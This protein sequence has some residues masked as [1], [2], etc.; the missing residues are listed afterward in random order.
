M[1][2]LGIM[3]LSAAERAKK[4]RDKHREEVRRRDNLRKKYQRTILKTL[5]ERNEERLRKQREQKSLYRKKKREEEQQT[6]RHIPPSTTSALPI[7]PP[8]SFTQNS[9]KAR[10]LRK[11]AAALP[12]SPSKKVEIV[13]SLAKKFNLRIQYDNR[14]SPGRPK[15]ELSEEEREWLES[16]FERPDITYTTPGRKDQRYLGKK[17]GESQYTQV[18]YLLWNLQDLLDILNGCAMTESGESFQARFSKKISF[19][20]MYEFVKSH[21]EF[22]FN[23]DIP[24]SSCLCEIC[25]NI[26]YLANSLFKNLGEELPTNPHA[27]VE[28]FACDSGVPACMFGECNACCFG[29]KTDY[30]GDVDDANLSSP[31]WKRVEGKVRKVDIEMSRQELIEEFN[32]QIKILKKH[33]Y[34]KREQNKFYNNLKSTLKPSEILIHVDYSENYAN[35]EQQEIQSAYFGHETFSIFTACCYLRG[36]DQELINE[37]ITITS[38]SSDHSR[39]AAHTC[40]LRV[41]EELMKSF[42]DMFS[43]TIPIYVWSD[44]C[45]SQFRSRFVFDLISRMERRFDI[46]WCYNERHHGKGPMDGLGGT[47][48]NKVFRDVKSGKV[49]ILDAKSFSDYAN[50][51]IENINSLYLSQNQILKEPEDLETAPKIPSTL[52]VHKVRRIYSDGVCKLEFYKIATDEIPFHEQWY[53]RKGDPEICG[54]PPLPLAFDQEN[55]CAFCRRDYLGHEDWLECQLCEQWFHENCFMT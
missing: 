2:I 7:T 3:P 39:I 53:R 15:N 26:V 25:E 11:A 54:H 46:T 37:N 43:E 24:Q 22:V 4:Y 8:P 16:F 31:Q 27:L 50:S 23:K 41:I 44:G 5:P 13:K 38:E 32:R 35:K 20:Q 17:D 45:A 48:K 1:T 36:P 6:L 55:V 52:E 42:K 34:I 40:V 47:I 29:F 19:R 49:R 33:I 51:A 10:S 9:T 18:R 21:R 14:I 28:K 12:K 30:E